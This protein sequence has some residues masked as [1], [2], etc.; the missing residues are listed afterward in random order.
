MKKEIVIA[1]SAPRQRH[2]IPQA[3]KFGDLVFT[4]GIAPRDPRT[5][6]PLHGDIA[7]QVRQALETLKTVL[8]AAGTGLD[9]VLKLT[10][11]LRDM[12][13]F[14]VWNGVFHEYFGQNPPARMTF[15]V[16]LVYFPIEV[17]AIACIPG[18]ES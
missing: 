13:D 18:E 16:P 11:Y 5:G 6:E 14:E 9:N 17:D 12:K 2:K 3:T 4:S 7:S 8:E 15:Q 10:C 1:S